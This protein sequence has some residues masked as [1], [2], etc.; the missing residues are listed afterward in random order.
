MVP[1]DADKDA[2]VCCEAPKPGAAPKKAAVS[3]FDNPS[4]ANAA[5][6]VSSGGGGGFNFGSGAAPSTGGAGGGFSFGGGG[7]GGK[8]NTR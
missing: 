6:A 8:A 1:N 5:F 7:G 2:C 3:A 4:K